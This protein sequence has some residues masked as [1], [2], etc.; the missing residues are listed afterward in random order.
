M[1]TPFKMNQSPH[2]TGAIEGTPLHQAALIKQGLKYIPKIFKKVKS[3]FTKTKSKVNPKNP[4][5]DP[6]KAKLTPIS[7]SNKLRT[8][9]SN[10]FI[11]EGVLKVK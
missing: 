10:T 3:L 1:A 9:Y 2:K 8:D 7:N 6:N 5:V 11:R 4:F